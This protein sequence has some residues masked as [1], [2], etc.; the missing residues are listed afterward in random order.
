MASTSSTISNASS[1]AITIQLVATTIVQEAIQNN[2]RQDH[3][4]Q[5]VTHSYQPREATEVLFSSDFPVSKYVR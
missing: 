1:S 3:L 2:R 4:C 5:R